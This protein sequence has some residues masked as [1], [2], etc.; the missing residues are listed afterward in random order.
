MASLT[1]RRETALPRREGLAAFLDTLRPT[2][3]RCTTTG[4]RKLGLSR[5]TI[6]LDGIFLTVRETTTDMAMA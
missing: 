3:P 6:F 5:I 1:A 2:R 4:W